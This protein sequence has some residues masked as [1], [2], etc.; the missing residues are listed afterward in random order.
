MARDLA[1][2]RRL[3]AKVIR[4]VHSALVHPANELGSGEDA[5]AGSAK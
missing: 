4:N 2:H 1:I 5:L 3:T